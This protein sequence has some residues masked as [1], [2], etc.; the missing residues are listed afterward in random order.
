M[1]NTVI[2]KQHLRRNLKARRLAHVDAIPP[3]QRNLLF[4][5]PPTALANLIPADAVIS[6]YHEMPG[7][8]PA[9]HYARWFY[10]QGHRVALPWFADRAAPMAFREW[11]NPFV[12]DLLVPDPFRAVQ[13]ASDAAELEPQIVFVPLLGFTATGER[14]GYGGGHYDRW[15]AAHPEATAI[16]LAWDCQLVESLPLEAHDIPLAAIVTPTRLYGPF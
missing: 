3:A 7:E 13:P 12:E 4:R 16:G 1:N 9:T 8:A 6:V 15:L 5:R 14:I 11:A 10:E 2:D